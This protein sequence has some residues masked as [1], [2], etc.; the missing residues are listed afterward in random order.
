MIMGELEETQ[1]K[2]KFMQGLVSDY[3]E[4]SRKAEHF[5]ATVKRLSIAKPINSSY[6][7]IA[8]DWHNRIKYANDEL[9]AYRRRV[10]G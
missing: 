5:E 1:K 8:D 3:N 7:S 9:E 6:P 4:I 10:N 2:I